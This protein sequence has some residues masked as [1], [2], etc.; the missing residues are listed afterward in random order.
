M[1]FAQTGEAL[2]SLGDDDLYS[3]H[4]FVTNIVYTITIVTQDLNHG[5]IAG[6]EGNVLWTSKAKGAGAVDI[7]YTGNQG[8]VESVTSVGSRGNGESTI[9][10][11]AYSEDGSIVP[12]SIS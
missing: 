1:D 10:Y 6:D 3:R 8:R 12:V 2:N 4:V 5:V 9:V 11:L 7:T